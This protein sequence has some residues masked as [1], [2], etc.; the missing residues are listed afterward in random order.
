MTHFSIKLHSNKKGQDF[1][2]KPNDNHRPLSKILLSPD[3]KP[4]LLFHFVHLHDLNFT[5]QVWFRKAEYRRE[6]P[7]GNILF[8]KHHQKSLW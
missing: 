1:N 3:T 8:E 6:N 5:L 7:R 4:Q 2:R